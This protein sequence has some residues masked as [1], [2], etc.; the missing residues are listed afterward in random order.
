MTGTPGAP[1][2][3]GDDR[4]PAVAFARF[5]GI[6]VALSNGSSVNLARKAAVRVTQRRTL[7]D[8]RSLTNAR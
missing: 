1:P 7:A 3:N 6:R 4:D 5:I 8:E 2:T